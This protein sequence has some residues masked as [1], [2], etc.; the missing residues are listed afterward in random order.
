MSMQKIT[1]GILGCGWWGRNIIRTLKNDFEQV[2]IICFDPSFE[3]QEHIKRD[4]D[5]NITDDIN[6]IFTSDSVK[7]VCIS[8]PPETHY[9][10]SKQALIRGKHVFV[11]K[12]PTLTL[13]EL[14]ELHE[15][16]VSKSCIYMLDCLFLFSDPI[17][18][19]KKLIDNNF[20]KDIEFVQL[21][22]IGDEIRRQEVGINGI[23]NRMFRN[24]INVVED[25]FYHDAGILIHLF[26]YGFRISN[27][28]KLNIYNNTYND[29]IF[30]TL[31]R[32]F[33]I[34]M[35]LSWV[36]T[37]RRRGITI[38]DSE[39]IL[40]YDAYNID[41]IIKIFWI[42]TQEYQT[43]PYNQNLPLTDI[44]RYFIKSIEGNYYYDYIGNY[45]FMREIFKLKSS[46]PS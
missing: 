40:E 6:Y 32:D 31:I 13:S 9:E 8:S 22:R 29:S 36:L 45:S 41:N 2:D 3:A 27:S 33:K 4:F 15:I 43:I 25:L 19:I 35:E 44:I 10:I 26:G 28:D 23:R 14:E 20:F 30:L 18:K 42:E 7:A 12:P 37:G 11:E 5:V 16:S 38:F 34:R 39:K 46:I 24:N 17:L 1:V 21:T